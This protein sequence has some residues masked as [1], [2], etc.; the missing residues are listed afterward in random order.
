[1]A[2]LDESIVQGVSGGVRNAPPHC[3]LLC[4]VL[5]SSRDHVGE[6]SS[7]ARLVVQSQRTTG[8]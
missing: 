7:D 4:P 5:V 1:M 2:G 3:V 6:L 8:G